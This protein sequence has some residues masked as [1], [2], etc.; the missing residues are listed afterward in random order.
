[1]IKGNDSS[2]CTLAARRT[3]TS[4]KSVFA[5][6]RTASDEHGEVINDAKD[7][8]RGGCRAY[9]AS[10]DLRVALGGETSI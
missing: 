8:E 7:R 9:C 3:G 10:N 6:L 2:A 4:V 1:M 5:E